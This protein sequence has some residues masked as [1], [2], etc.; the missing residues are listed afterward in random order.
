MKEIFDVIDEIYRDLEKEYQ[1]KHKAITMQDLV[2]FNNLKDQNDRL[3]T[4]ICKLM[5][6]NKALKE[7]N[8][9]HQRMIEELEKEIQILKNKADKKNS[10]SVEAFIAYI[11]GD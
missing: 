11:L 5:Q 7:A 10:D 2:N 9:S 4:S 3:S 1:P 8:K 6:E